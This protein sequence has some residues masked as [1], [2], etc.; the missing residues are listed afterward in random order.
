MPEVLNPGVGHPM[1]S[2]VDKLNTFF[3]ELLGVIEPV[4]LH[5]ELSFT[6]NCPLLAI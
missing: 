1:P 6:E 2:T 5:P 3:P 4:E